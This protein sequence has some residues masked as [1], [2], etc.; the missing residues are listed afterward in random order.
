MQGFEHAVHAVR[1]L[2]DAGVEAD[3]TIFGD[4]EYLPA[5]AFARHQLEI[6]EQVHLP[7]EINT[8][9]LARSLPTADVFVSAAVVDGMPKGVLQAMAS[10][11][12]VVMSDPGPLGSAG[13]DPGAGFVVPRRDP[14]ALAEKLVLLA[15]DEQMRREMGHAGR[16][17][18]LEHLDRAERLDRVSRLYREALA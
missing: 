17:W 13:I 16:R 5:L 9:E 11:I 12:P 8:P 10:G 7:G 3:Y 15:G 18:A 14:R 6:R 1:L 2:L 4:G